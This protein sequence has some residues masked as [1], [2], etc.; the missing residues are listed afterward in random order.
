MVNIYFFDASDSSLD[1]S[2]ASFILAF[3]FS[4]SKYIGRLSQNHS[5]LT[6]L[7]SLN[8]KER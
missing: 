3:T 4:L 2:Y 1:V 7:P 8:W 5:Y 6:I